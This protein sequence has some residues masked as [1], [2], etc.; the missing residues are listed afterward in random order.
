M[1]ESKVILFREDWTIQADIKSW[2][3]IL[4][5]LNDNGWKPNGFLTSFLGNREVCEFEAAQINVVGQKILDQ[6]I[7]DPISL[8]PVSF[9]MG[10]FAE[11]ISFCEE[12]T[13]QISIKYD[14]EVL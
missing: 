9:D 1:E 5:F 3:E 11:I 2:A 4:L 10:K 14:M 7:R 12:G 13:F 8:Y 6:A